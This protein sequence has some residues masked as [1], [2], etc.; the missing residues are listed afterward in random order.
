MVDGADSIGAVYILWSC[1][2]MM[3]YCHCL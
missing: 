1:Q 2:F 3:I